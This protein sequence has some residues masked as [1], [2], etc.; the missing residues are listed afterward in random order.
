MCPVIAL[1]PFALVAL[2]AQ[3]EPVVGPVPVPVP[4]PIVCGTWDTGPRAAWAFDWNG[5][6]ANGDVLADP[7]DRVVFIAFDR[8]ATDPQPRHFVGLDRSLVAGVTEVS[9]VESL[10]GIPEGDWDLVVQIRSSSGQWSGTSER[11][12]IRIV[13]QPAQQRPAPVSGLR[14]AGGAP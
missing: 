5:L 2:I 11:L 13:P 6:A 1:L 10:R 4:T 7:I 12:W 9:W 3:D 14:Q 8:S